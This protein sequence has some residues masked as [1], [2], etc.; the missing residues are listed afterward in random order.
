[1]IDFILALYF[2]LEDSSKL[3]SFTEM[4]PEKL[5]CLNEKLHAQT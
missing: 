4:M 2:F 1:M 5:N 3:I